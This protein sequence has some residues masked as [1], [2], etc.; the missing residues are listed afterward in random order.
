MRRCWIA[1]H[2]VAIAL[3]A[4]NASLSPTDR[5]GWIA[6]AI[7]VALLLVF[8]LVER[9]LSRWHSHASYVMAAFDCNGRL[10]HRFPRRAAPGDR[11]A[12]G[13]Y[14]RGE[15]ERGMERTR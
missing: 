12:C 5:A 14:T 7:L 10:G 1:L 2:V 11:C 8:Y 3:C 6:E 9:R 4:V 15:S 13:L